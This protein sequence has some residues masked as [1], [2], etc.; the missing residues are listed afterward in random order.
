MCSI[1]LNVIRFL[2]DYEELFTAHPSQIDDMTTRVLYCVNRAGRKLLAVLS[3]SDVIAQEIS[4]R[5]GAHENG[6][7]DEGTRERER[8]RERA[9][10][11]AIVKGVFSPISSLVHRCASFSTDNSSS[12]KG[13]HSSAT[14]NGN[15]TVSPVS[16]SSTSKSS[17]FRD[18]K[19]ATWRT[20]SVERLMFDNSDEA[21]VRGSAARSHRGTGSAEEVNQALES[22]R[23]TL[24]AAET[25]LQLRFQK[26]GDDYF[27]SLGDL[28]HSIGE[29]EKEGEGEGE[30]GD[31]AI[32]EATEEELFL[33]AA[34]YEVRV[35]CASVCPSVCLPLCIDAYHHHNHYCYYSD[36]S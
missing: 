17:S 27:E 29:G 22:L 11:Q 28:F 14:G 10:T 5:D 23:D 21:V 12:E 2:K 33:P 36:L 34:V 1:H 3:R 35:F 25:V 26:R 6:L 24:V 31:I 8:E 7:G 15:G 4:T 30:G 16:P 9:A 19:Y 20:G 18:C 32:R 13:A